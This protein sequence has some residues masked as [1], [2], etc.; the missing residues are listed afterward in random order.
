MKK[1]HQGKMSTVGLQAH[2]QADKL[3]QAAH[4]LLGC[5]CNSLHCH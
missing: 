4:M 3:T 1:F 5:L 2:T